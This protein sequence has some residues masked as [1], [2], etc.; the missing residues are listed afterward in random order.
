MA[1]SEQKAL[2]PALRGIFWGILFGENVSLSD[3]VIYEAM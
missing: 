1:L 3:L 2:S